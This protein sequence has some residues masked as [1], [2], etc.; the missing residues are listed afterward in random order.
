MAVGPFGEVAKIQKR[1]STIHAPTT[2]SAREAGEATDTPNLNVAGLRPES[3]EP[4]SGAALAVYRGHI[5]GTPVWSVAFA[6]CSYYF[7]SAGGDGTAR[8]WTTDRP[9]PVRLF[10]GH[11]SAS[12]NTVEWHPNCNYI[13]TGCEDRTVRLWD[14]QTGRCVRL[15]N[16]CRA[17]ISVVKICPSGRYAA[18][19]D[20]S[21]VIHIWDL[22]TGKKVNEL[23]DMDGNH[24]VN[25]NQARQYPWAANH[26]QGVSKMV[27]T[28]SYS[29]CGST[30]ASGGDD[31]CVRI[32][33]VRGVANH[34]GNPDYASRQ[35]WGQGARPSAW[36]GA[37]AAVRE[38]YKT[39][40]TRRTLILDLHFT[41]RNLLLS[42][43]KFVS[44]A[45]PVVI[46][47]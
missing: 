42:V 29:S 43:G 1:S 16:G 36:D 32:W 25:P 4:M 8:L 20:Y 41:R 5:P 6:P 31:C 45:T 26:H 10:A 28:L 21:G 38:P 30:L 7:C 35:G 40:S 9:S 14:I 46:S 15:L 27:H 39:F 2:T 37:A 17:G 3:T 33:D 47:D 34:M 44:T 19:A 18:G 23:R 11:T 22:G 12:V 24:A 13:L